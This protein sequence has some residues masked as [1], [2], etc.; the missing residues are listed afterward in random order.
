MHFGP[1]KQMLWFLC[2]VF[3]FYFAIYFY[4]HYYLFSCMCWHALSIIIY[5]LAFFCFFL[6]KF[7]FVC[8][9]VVHIFEISLPWHLW[10]VWSLENSSG[11]IFPPSVARHVVCY[12]GSVLATERSCKLNASSWCR[13]RFPHVD[14]YLCKFNFH[15][16]RFVRVGVWVYGWVCVCVYVYKCT[17]VCVCAKI[18]FAAPSCLGFT[19]SLLLF[20]GSK[21]IFSVIAFY[22]TW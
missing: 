16:K 22:Q 21:S 6:G 17:L 1:D 3:Q 4:S 10:L 12:P 7:N 19:Y 2:L 9:P 15:T 8:A 18:H 11:T 14:V 13:C 20:L 5:F